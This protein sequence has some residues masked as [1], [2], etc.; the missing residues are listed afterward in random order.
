MKKNINTLHAEWNN[1]HDFL[2]SDFFFKIKFFKYSISV[3]DQAGDFVG[4]AL[5]LYCFQRLSAEGTSK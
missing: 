5:N 3:P 4:S 1:F 2:S